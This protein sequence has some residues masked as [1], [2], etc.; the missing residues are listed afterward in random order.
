M[1]NLKTLET[2]VKRM[3]KKA[4]REELQD[5]LRDVEAY[6]KGNAPVWFT[7]ELYEASKAQ[8]ELLENKIKESEDTTNG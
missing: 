8:I 2:C 4:M 5:T 6:E 3:G 1:K 7:K